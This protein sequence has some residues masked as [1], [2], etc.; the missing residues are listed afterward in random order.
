M[1]KA[2]KLM[3]ALIVVFIIFLAYTVIDLWLDRLNMKRV[4]SQPFTDLNWREYSIEFKDLPNNPAEGTMIYCTNCSTRIFFNP[5]CIQG[6]EIILA[7]YLNGIWDCKFTG[8][9]VD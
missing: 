7:V 4:I 1:K 3:S 5:R 8:M 9:S 6:D 2:Y